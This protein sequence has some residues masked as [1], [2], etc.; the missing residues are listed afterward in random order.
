MFSTA[1][2]L[3]SGNQPMSVCIGFTLLSL[4]T[5]IKHFSLSMGPTSKLQPSLKDCGILFVTVTA[6]EGKKNKSK[7]KANVLNA[8]VL[9]FSHLGNY[10]PSSK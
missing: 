4:D 9:L 10:I 5:S 8:V 3:P 1:Q 6:F 7:V 2:Y